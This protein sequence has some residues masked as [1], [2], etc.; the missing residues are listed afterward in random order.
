MADKR[1]YYEVLGVSKSASDDEI[2]KAYRQAAKKNH[3]DLNPGDTAAEARFK[4]ANE[5]Y[6][7]LSD[8]QKKARYD[9]FGHAGVDPN[10][11]GGGGFG[12]FGGFEGGGFDLNDIFN[13]FSGSSGFG[14]GRHAN[15]NAPR[16]G[17]DLEER[18]TISFEESAKGVSR[19]ITVNRIETCDQCGGTGVAPGGHTS[20]CPDCHGTGQ[21]TIQSKTPFGVIQQSRTCGKCQGKGQIIDNP[22]PQC[23]GGG[24]VRKRHPVQ[25]DIPA[26]INEG[27]VL[28]YP[29][30]GNRGTNGGPA[31]D[32]LVAILIRPHPFFERDGY[33]TWC[34]LTLQ[35]WQVAMGDT[36]QVPT[37]DGYEP[38]KVPAGTQPGTVLTLRSKGI[39]VLKGGGRRGDLNVRIKVAIPDASAAGPKA[40]FEPLKAMYP[41]AG[42]VAPA[43]P[44]EDDGK[45]GF[46]NRNKKK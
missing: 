22:C 17:S 30:E 38:L 16:R 2:K 29:G 42:T 27:Q 44:D 3:P 46:F 14:G 34:E 19:T 7:V 43:A 13:M 21:V 37:L 31:G 35:V 1:D 26:G 20:T 28:H 12:G 25:V 6:E 23:R 41:S 33:H 15:P 18:V 5:A 8:P 10:M 9:Q 24:R 11:A 36:V 4:E 45:R 40:L 39:P 32:L